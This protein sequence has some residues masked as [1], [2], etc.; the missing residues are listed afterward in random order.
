LNA[1]K[2]AAW[3]M[4]ILAGIE[5]Y[6]P[7][8]KAP[9]KPIIKHLHQQILPASNSRDKMYHRQRPY[10]RLNSPCTKNYTLIDIK[11]IANCTGTTIVDYSI[12][13]E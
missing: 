10:C 4:Q 3:Q 9:G 2:N 12:K 5:K 1:R 7:F 6:S 8:P 13:H 11:D